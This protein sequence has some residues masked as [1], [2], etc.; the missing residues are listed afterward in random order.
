MKV[1]RTN[2]KALFTP[3]L[4][5][6]QN[7]VYQKPIT[8]GLHQILSRATMIAQVNK[9][10]LIGLGKKLT[11]RTDGRPNGN[12]PVTF[13][14]YHVP[15]ENSADKAIG[16]FDVPTIDHS[17][18][19]HLELVRWT[20]QEINNVAPGSEVIV[21]TDESFARQIEDLKPTIVIPEVEKIDRCITE[22]RLII[23]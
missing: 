13:V 21:C 22:Q 20:I 6:A 2:S 11:L 17:R 1:D 23:Q 19:K 18:I 3:M 4:S 8:S 10:K 14:I 12:S 5:I 9:E 7:L 15:F 16:S